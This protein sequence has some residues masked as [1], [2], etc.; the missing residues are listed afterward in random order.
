M[1]WADTCIV[2]AADLVYG[3]VPNVLGSH[4][5]LRSAGAAEAEASWKSALRLNGGREPRG[6]CIMTLGRTFEPTDRQEIKR[7]SDMRPESWGVGS[8]VGDS[9]VGGRP[10][11]EPLTP[12]CL[13][14]P[15][16]MPRKGS[17]CCQALA[18]RQ[19]T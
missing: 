17:L 6:K 4:E 3:G 11:A 15:P 14:V 8:V 2:S 13:Y 1:V 10:G 12:E 7:G 16:P 5:R 19:N 9:E 18:F